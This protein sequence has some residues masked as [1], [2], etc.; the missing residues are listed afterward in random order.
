MDETLIVMILDLSLNPSENHKKVRK[1]YELD[2][3]CQE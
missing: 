3:L 2:I 1:V